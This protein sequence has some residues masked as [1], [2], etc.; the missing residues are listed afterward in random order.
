MVEEGGYAL[1]SNYDT[2]GK[3]PAETMADSRLVLWR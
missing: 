1:T 3:P 2:A